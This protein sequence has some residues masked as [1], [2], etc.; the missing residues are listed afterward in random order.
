MKRSPEP[1]RTIAMIHETPSSAAS[2][3]STSGRR[4]I[5]PRHRTLLAAS[6]VMDGERLIEMVW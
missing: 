1:Q 5:S 2:N 3:A 6:S 4:R